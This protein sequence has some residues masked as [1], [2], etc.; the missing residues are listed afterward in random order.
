M[1]PVMQTQFGLQGNCLSACIASLLELTIEEVPNFHEGVAPGAPQDDPEG[2]KIFWANVHRFINSKGFG[3]FHM[4]NETATA[5]Q[6]IMGGYFLVGGKSPR[7]YSHSVIWTKNGLA[8]DP[9]PEGGGVEFESI[10]VIYP[11]FAG[12]ALRHD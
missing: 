1:K 12:D 10:S 7:G 5:L 3:M 2:C 8:H 4:V 9:H 11:L 6:E